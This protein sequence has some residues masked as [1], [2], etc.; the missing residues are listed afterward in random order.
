MWAADT[1]ILRD[2]LVERRGG[3]DPAGPDVPENVATRPST[4]H[5]RLAEVHLVYEPA[6]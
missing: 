1:G 2:W 6:E 3:N 5:G 4:R